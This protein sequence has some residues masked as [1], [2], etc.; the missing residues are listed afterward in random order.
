MNG[1]EGRTAGTGARADQVRASARAGE[2][3]GPVR[4]L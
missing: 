4:R 3:A 1:A 2:E